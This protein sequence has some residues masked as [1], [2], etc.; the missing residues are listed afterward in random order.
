MIIIKKA[1]EEIQQYLGQQ[2]YKENNTF[3][4]S[5]F[6]VK[7]S[8]PIG[9]LLYNTF[10]GEIVLTNSFDDIQILKKNGIIYRMNMTNFM[11]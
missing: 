3:H 4:T 10:T 8:T 1:Y 5:V 11:C 7:E 9:D 2:K 6:V